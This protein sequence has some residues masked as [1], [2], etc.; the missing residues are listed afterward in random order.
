MLYRQSQWS[1]GR[2][3][4]QPCL[5]S[6]PESFVTAAEVPESFYKDVISNNAT[7]VAQYQ[8][9]KESIRQ[10]K[11][12]ET[13]RFWLLLYLDL[14]QTQHLIHLAVQDNDFEMRLHCWKF[15]LTLY[16]ALQKMNYARYGSYYY[17]VKV[18]ENI[19]K[20]YPGLK[21]VLF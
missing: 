2:F 13:P 21:D 6:A 18:M 4:L 11:L 16:F 14:M 12:G 20:M 8:E 10:G 17:Y 3:S 5:E 15:Y 1:P 7:F 19:E 9:F